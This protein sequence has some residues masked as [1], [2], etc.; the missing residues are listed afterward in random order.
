MKL[1][2]IIVRDVDADSVVQALIEN[3][4]RVTRM[5]STGGLMRHGNVTLMIGI[6]EDQVQTVINLLQQACCPPE[7]SHHRATIFVVDMPYF[8]QI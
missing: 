4:Y 8:E 7:D 3:H 6:I 1:M 5:A 2:F